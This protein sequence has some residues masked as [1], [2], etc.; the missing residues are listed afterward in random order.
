VA[1]VG[2]GRDVCRGEPTAGEAALLDGE[3][4]VAVARAVPAGW[5]PAVVLG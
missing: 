2:H 5:H 3:R 1:L 4:L